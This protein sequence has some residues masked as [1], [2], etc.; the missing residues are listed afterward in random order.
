MAIYSILTATLW[1]NV[2]K[3]EK[4]DE[5]STQLNCFSPKILLFVAINEKTYFNPNYGSVYFDLDFR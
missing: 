1:E 2:R 4:H 3:P 5:C